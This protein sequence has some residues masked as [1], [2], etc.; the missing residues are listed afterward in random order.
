M[1]H[2][3][4]CPDKYEARSK[5]RRDAEFDLD[6]Y[7][8]GSCLEPYDCEEANTEYRREYDT[9]ASRLE[10]ERAMERRAEQRRQEERQRE[11]CEMQRAYEEEQRR[12]YET[13]QQQA[14]EEEIRKDT[15]NG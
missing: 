4:N 13:E 10:E 14:Y 11:E 15:T 9:E 8:R 12:A 6:Y 2:R 1:S 3:W 7:G 5:A